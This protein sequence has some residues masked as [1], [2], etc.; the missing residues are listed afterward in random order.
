LVHRDIVEV[1]K[2]LFG[3]RDLERFITLRYY[4]DVNKEGQ[5]V[6]SEPCSSR[7]FEDYERLVDTRFPE[8]RDKVPLAMM[9]YSDST[10]LTQLAN[11]QKAWIVYLTLA[12]IDSRVRQSDKGDCFIPVAFLAAPDT[13]EKEK[14]NSYL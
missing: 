4:E 7:D 10:N 14:V 11:G 9:L 13:N 3:R 1:I 6:Y 2:I 8:I 5:R 12:N